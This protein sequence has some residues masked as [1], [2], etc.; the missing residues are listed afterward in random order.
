MYSAVV[1]LHTQHILYDAY[2]PFQ[3]ISNPSSSGTA[4]FID[5]K[6][7]ITCFHC[8]ELM[9]K[10]FISDPNLSKKQYPVK[11]VSVIPN[12]DIAL[13]ELVDEDFPEHNI[14][15]LGNSDLIKSLDKVI[16]LGFPMD[17]DSL[18][19]TQ[20]VISG[21]KHELFQTDTPLNPGNSGGPLLFNDKVIGINTSKLSHAENMGFSVPINF[22]KK[23]YNYIL[24][25]KD[26]IIRLPVLN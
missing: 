5:K 19:Y 9:I 20:G 17:S 4:F 16:A 12:L 18:I 8:V 1:K 14:L 11:I 10:I 15:E 6:L 26:V 3:I 2:A 7:L 25:S 23:W 21:K 24:Q 22:L 13:L